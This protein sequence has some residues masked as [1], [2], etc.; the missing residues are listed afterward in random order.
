MARVCHAEELHPPPLLAHS[1][2]ATR[3]TDLDAAVRAAQN[4][5][6]TAFRLLYRR[7][8]PRLLRYVRT[9]VGDDAEDVTSEAWLQIIRDLASFT[10]DTDGFRAWTATIARNRALDHLRR[11]KRRPANA[12]AD[13]LPDQI[14]PDDTAKTAL[15]FMSTQTALRLITRLPREQ[16][17]I[18][19]LRVV[20]GLDVEHVAKLLGKRPGTVR[21]AT[22]RGLRRL[23]HILNELEQPR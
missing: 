20:I 15:D 14:A 5:D 1:P 11:N 6:E 16:A 22:Y 4:G 12:P 10:G 9:L 8:Q 7:L 13:E 2:S 3:A 18:I 19:I 23:Q 17:E 21:T